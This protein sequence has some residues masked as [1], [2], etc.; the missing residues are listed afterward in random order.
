MFGWWKELLDIR[1]E[2]R[3]RKLRLQEEQI[4]NTRVC[5]SCEVLKVQLDLANREK[6][7]LLSKLLE[8]PEPESERTVAVPMQ[9]LPTKRHLSWNVRRQILEQE[10]RAKAASM[11]NAA[12]PDNISVEDLEKELDVVEREREAQSG[13]TT[14]RTS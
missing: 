9:T 13:P 12:Q 14:G 5:Q 1:Y 2:F 10:D 11:R 4:Q 7:Q 6:A 3:E 8:K